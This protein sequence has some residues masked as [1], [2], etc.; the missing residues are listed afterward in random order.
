MPKYYKISSKSVKDTRH[1]ITI[2]SE[3][4]KYTSQV[5][6]YVCV[7]FYTHQFRLHALF[8]LQ[9]ICFRTLFEQHSSS[10]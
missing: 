8:E 6:I 2:L 9:N 4:G 5:K 10:L 7:Q 1:I 3:H